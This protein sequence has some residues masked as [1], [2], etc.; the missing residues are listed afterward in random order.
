MPKQYYVALLSPPGARVSPA[1]A[2]QR[3]PSPV[4]I[5][6][7]TNPGNRSSRPCDKKGAPA[8]LDAIK[9]VSH[10]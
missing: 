2:V 10:E 3:K 7:Q 1:D 4:C 5:L 8:L 9:G 6:L